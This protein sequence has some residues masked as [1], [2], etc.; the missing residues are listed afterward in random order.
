MASLDYNGK[1]KTSY[2]RYRV[3]GRSYRKNIGKTT[4][5]TA[6]QIFRKFEDTLALNKVGINV[7][8]SILLEDFFCEYFEWVQASQSKKTFEVKHNSKIAF[9]RFLNKRKSSLEKS[10]TLQSI[11]LSVVEKFKVFRIQEGVSN[12]TINI[13]LTFLSHC[14]KLGK[15]WGYLVSEFKIKQIK[16]VKK[17]PR[18]LSQEEVTLI[19][20]HSNDYLKSFIKI[21]LLTGFRISELLNLKW[22]QVDLNNGMIHL[23]NS[24]DF[25]T[26]T[27]TDREIPINSNLKEA[28]LEIKDFYYI[29]TTGKRYK[30]LDQHKTY[31]I[32]NTEGKRMNSVRKS[33][34]RL[35]SKLNIK[36][37]TLHTLRH[38]FASFG[39][40]N[41]V[42]L[43]T[44][45]DLLGHT[46][47]TTTE[48][49]AHL[50][51]EHKKNAVEKISPVLGFNS[52][53]KLK[54][55]KTGS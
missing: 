42:D 50:N 43:Y 7:P 4:L 55:F 54:V 31:V 46:R 18:F 45:K 26:K 25:K 1:E 21:L 33:Y 29:P 53:N 24:T 34:G 35:L 13:D 41:G 44:L 52:T 23:V 47:V 2:I 19:L 48:I 3:N 38:T 15:E 6:K 8:R 37:A 5:T 32:C 30:R 22:E 10:F 14:L 36:H 49:Y 40:M 20:E 39:V 28:L 27:R 51:R 12:R 9:M 11:T 16:E 17:L